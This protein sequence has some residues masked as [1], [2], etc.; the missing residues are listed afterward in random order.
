MPKHHTHECS[1]LCIDRKNKKCLI[2][3]K[4]RFRKIR[5]LPEKEYTWD[6]FIKDIYKFFNI[7][8]KKKMESINKKLGLYKYNVKDF[9]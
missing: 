3:L 4:K 1:L 6:M 2:R 7:T 8:S 5:D 9:F